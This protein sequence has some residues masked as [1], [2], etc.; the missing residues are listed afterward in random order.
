MKNTIT[1]LLVQCFILGSISAQDP[2]TVAGRI[3]DESASPVPFANLA[4]YSDADSVLIKVDASDGE[5][6]F[7]IPL[8][9][10][11]LVFLQISA[12]GY[13]TRTISGLTVD[14][15]ENLLLGDLLLTTTSEQLGEVTVTAQRSVLEVKPDKLVFN[16]EESISATGNNALD[17]LR[18]SPGVIVDNSDQI[19]LAGRAGVQVYIN[20]KQSPYSGDDLATFL[21]NL[22]SDQVEAIEVISNPS[23]RY[24][25]E[26][27]GGI[28]N[29]RLKKDQSLGANANLQLGSST[30]LRPVYNGGLTGNYRNQQIN[31]YGSYNHTN[32]RNWN[33]FFMLRQQPGGV[34]D[35]T[36]ITES[37]GLNHSFKLGT[38]VFLS[39]KSTVGF[40]INGFLNDYE[41]DGRTRTSLSTGPGAPI[42]SILLSANLSDIQRQ[43]YHANLNYH[44]KADQ[45]RSW[46]IDLDYGWFRN[47]TVQQLP[48]QY[49]G[50][51]EKTMLSRV[52]YA[53]N[54][55]TDID[56]WTIRADRRQPLG[57]GTLE[58]GIKLAW[59]RTDNTFDW[60][61]VQG[62][63]RI[64]DF[65]RTNRFQYLENVNAAYATYAL[66]FAEKWR[67]QAGVRGEYTRTHA[68]LIA[69]KETS[70]AQVDSN[71]LNLFPSAGLTYQ[72][73]PKHS[74]RFN[75]SRRIN[76]PNYQ[77]LNPF[78]FRT[79]E[80]S[81]SRG[82]PFLR[83]EY[84]H[85]LELSHTFNYRFTTS[86][87]YSVTNDLITRI[88]DIGGEKS[89]FITWLNLA[90]QR[91]YSLSLS[92]PVTFTEWWRSYSSLT[93]YRVENQADYGEGRIVD[94]ARNTLN[95]YTQQTFTLG[96]GF[97]AELSGWYQSP[98]VWGGTFETDAM[99][100]INIGL[101][102]EWLDGRANLRLSVNDIFFSSGWTATS[103]LGQ[104]FQDGGGNWDSRRVQLSLRYRFGN[105]NVKKAR[106]RKTGLEEQAD[107]ASAN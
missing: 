18:K 70:N 3:L 28:I 71:Y 75:Y 58:A 78:E 81:F 101:Q 56:I 24:D 62:T 1:I 25:A 9:T 103:V 31:I 102:K 91:N 32:R 85:H 35:Q 29:I 106:A 26:G 38:D 65:D 22:Q 4:L 33:E 41:N 88:T 49:V 44:W 64:L 23:A 51:R 95:L 13:R 52:E 54:A 36:T 15:P 12:L 94:L 69:R 66:A 74:I 79:D 50:P 14:H 39:E 46:N 5:G 20:G 57:K 83:P 34:F 59:V 27:N 7:A 11:Q 60:Y 19:L 8:T 55:P 68:N 16:V 100:S 42:D 99:Y 97:T 37:H 80:L 96:K 21:R 105:L 43:N 73:S 53:N 63:E 89:T 86:L 82:N 107:R 10:D 72:P 47:R 67:L 30:G 2:L 87:S 90:S 84:A 61:D 40:L 45:D 98:S 93:A 76:R 17:L 92:S 48:N 6:R 104:L 77:D